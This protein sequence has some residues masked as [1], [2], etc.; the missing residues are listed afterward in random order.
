M[1]YLGKKLEA[2]KVGTHIL[3]VML[4]FHLQ[5]KFVSRHYKYA[6]SSTFNIQDKELV[7]EALT[8]STSINYGGKKKGKIKWMHLTTVSFL[9][10]Q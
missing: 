4:N 5:S 8:S 1:E 2:E 6:T 9:N 7:T 10:Q 3:Q